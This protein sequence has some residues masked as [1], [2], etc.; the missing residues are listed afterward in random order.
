MPPQVRVTRE[1][2]IDKAFELTREYGFDKVT[3]RMLASELNCST[4]PV[5]HVFRNMDELKYEVYLKTK[6]YF[7]KYMLRKSPDKNTPFV[8]GMGLRYI[9]L[10][11]KEKNLFRLLNTPDS[12][13]RLKSLYDLADDYSSDIDPDTFIKTWIFS[14]GI[15]SI[16]VSDET[17]ISKKEIKKLLTDAEMSFYTYGKDKQ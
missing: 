2:I 11:Q 13:R 17:K 10:A 9:D 6:D 8:L 7:D 1:A 5:Y 15:A 4:Q 3:A 16:V 12:G 14:H